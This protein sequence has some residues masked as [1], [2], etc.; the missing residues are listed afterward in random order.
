VDN[1]ALSATGK[2]ERVIEGYKDQPIGTFETQRHTLFQS[3]E[4]AQSDIVNPV[5]VPKILPPACTVI[6]SSASTA[7]SNRRSLL[8]TLRGPSDV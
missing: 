2:S 7:V 6:L 5:R 1:T 4:T 3:K 8:G